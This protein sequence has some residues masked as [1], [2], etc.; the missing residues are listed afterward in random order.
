VL[1]TIITYLAPIYIFQEVSSEKNYVLSDIARTKL[2]SKLVDAIEAG[3]NP[4][5]MDVI[6]G[7][8][9]ESPID[10]RERIADHLGG[11]EIARDWHKYRLFRASLSAEKIE[12]LA[13]M[14]FITRIDNNTREQVACMNT[15]RPYTHVTDLQ[16]YIPSM[17]GNTDGSSS[18]SKDDIVIA[19]L[20][21][22]ID[23][24]HHDLDQGKV[25]GW[26]DFINGEKSAYD[27]MGHGTHCASIAA[28]TGEGSSLYKGVAHGAALV[29]VKMMDYTGGS[30]KSIAIDALAWVGNNKD[31]YGIEIASCS[32]GFHD[33]GNYD[34]I[35]LMAD[36]LVYID[37]VVVCVAAGNEGHLG[38]N[39]I[40]N[41]GT[42]HHVVTVG[43]AVDPGEGGWE[44]W[45]WQDYGSGRGPADGRIKPD[46]LAPGVYIMAAEA[47]T[48]EGYIESTGTSMATPFIAGTIAIILDKYPQYRYDNDDDFDPDV[49]QLMMSSAVDMPDDSD[50]GKDNDFGSGRIDALDAYT[51]AEYDVSTSSSNAYLLISYQ[52]ASYTYYSEPLWCRDKDYRSDWFKVR[53]Y[54]GWLLSTTAYGD[55]DL[56]LR[57]RI[58]D[59]Y[60]NLVAESTVGRIK[61]VGYTTTYSGVYYIR[62]QSQ[63][64][65]GDYYDLSVTTTPS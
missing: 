58:Y 21:T 3:T 30:D 42:A 13:E 18:Y 36:R 27:D 31:I 26:V 28:G 41:P 32:W 6:V 33:Y 37:H 61:S 8:D 5:T 12:K 16:Y 2:D 62:I 20:D 60:L 9:M 55:P 17:D 4:E 53:I 38:Y 54:S 59:K 22:G 19:V 24:N 11:L 1:I 46:I 39:T 34:T 7:C 51:F 43:A 10:Y 29:G 50:P 44:V 35:S 63:E 52:D 45:R 49:K 56:L 14:S 25:I 47:G 23:K 40:R 57:L 48:D 64:Y 15:A 65:T